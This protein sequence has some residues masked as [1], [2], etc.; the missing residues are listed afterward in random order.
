MPVHL[1]GYNQ[2]T[3][4]HSVFWKQLQ[5]IHCRYKKK[6][7]RIFHPRMIEQINTYQPTRI[8]ALLMAEIFN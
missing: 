6:K 7:K 4:E 1:A 5:N 8:D 2:H 3:G